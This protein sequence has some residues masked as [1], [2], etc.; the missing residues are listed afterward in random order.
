MHATLGSRDGPPR[1]LPPRR[2]CGLQAPW[3]AHGF[4]DRT[5]GAALVIDAVR[6]IAWTVDPKGQRRL[7]PEGLYGRRKM[8]ALDRLRM[9]QAAPGSSD[10][11]MTRTLA[12]RRSASGDRTGSRRQVLPPSG[13]PPGGRAGAVVGPRHLKTKAVIS[14]G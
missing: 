14:L 3:Q 10:Q 9:P 5:I 4:S 8:T 6:D 13:P 12:G 2:P 1:E 7:T 11:A